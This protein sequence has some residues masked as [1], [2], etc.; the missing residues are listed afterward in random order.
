LNAITVKDKHPLPIVD[1]L[2]G[3]KWFSK[4]DC[5]SG[6]H[7]I[8][9]V[10]GDEMKTTFT[11]HH[12]LHDFKVMPFGLTNAPATFQCAMNELF[13]PLLRKGVLVF[14]DDILVYSSTLGSCSC[15]ATGK[16][17]MS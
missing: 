10:V 14:I 8:R 7:Q 6:Y 1:E 17:L 5:R 12:G 3:A 13:A 11:T 9:V 16:K 15:V 2:H 4:L